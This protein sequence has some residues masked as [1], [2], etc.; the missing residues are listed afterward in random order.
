MTKHTEYPTGLNKKDIDAI[1]NHFNN[2]VEAVRKKL[3]EIKSEVGAE[4]NKQFVGPLADA[5]LRIMILDTIIETCL[6]LDEECLR[7]SNDSR[8]SFN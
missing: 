6:F 7:R 1:F 4:Y 5:K 3:A 2:D 8:I